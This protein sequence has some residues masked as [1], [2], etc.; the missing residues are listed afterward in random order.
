[1]AKYYD[2]TS[3]DC[4]R[5]IDLKFGNQSKKDMHQKVQQNPIEIH[6]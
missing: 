2:F 4:G 1:M 3:H 6:L 5:V